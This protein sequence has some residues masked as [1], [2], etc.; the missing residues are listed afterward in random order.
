M[1]S[2]FVAVAG[3]PNVGK[4]TLVNAL[5]GEKIAITSIVPNTTRRRI[6]GI[7]NGND[8]SSSSSTC[9]AFSARWTRSPSACSRRVDELRRRRRRSVRRRRASAHRLGRPVRSAARVRPRPA[10]DDRAQQGRPAEAGAYR[11]ADE[12][13]AAFGDFHALHPVSAKTEATG[14]TSFAATS[15]YAPARRARATFRGRVDRPP[16]E[17]RIAEFIREKALQLT[18]EEV[19]HAVRPSSTRSRS[20]ACA[21]HLHC[22]TET[23]EGPIGK[24]G[25]WCARSAPARD[26][27]SSRCSAARVSP[28]PGQG[29]AE[30]AARRA[31]LERLGL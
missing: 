11:H 12:G 6:F 3:R 30:V 17:V 14:W 5:C 18:Q 26:P 28:A 4:S 24:G 23:P 7:A 9:P 31:M 29:R 19:P 16:L 25:R 27:R 21:S 2:G 20:S 1:K 22:E 8:Y 10:G 15:L 13:A